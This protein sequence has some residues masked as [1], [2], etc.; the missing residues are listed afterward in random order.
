MHLEKTKVMCNKHVNKDNVIVYGKTIEEV[1]S[2]VYLGKM[3]TK[4][5]D[6]IQEM[7]RRIGQGWNAT[8]C[9]TKMCQ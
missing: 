7:K 3:V 5:Y 4:G 2:Y 8:S 1:D 9:E 6:Q